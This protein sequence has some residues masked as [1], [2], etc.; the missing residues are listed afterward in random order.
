MY[1]ICRISDFCSQSKRGIKEPLHYLENIFF[2]NIKQIASWEVYQAVI[3]IG[4]P[5]RTKL[6]TMYSVVL[7]IQACQTGHTAQYK[8]AWSNSLHMTTKVSL[9]G[10][11]FQTSEEKKKKKKLYKIH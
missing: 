1:K 9:E 10:V 2:K 4:I 6:A 3:G 11:F 5:K 8:I 7:K